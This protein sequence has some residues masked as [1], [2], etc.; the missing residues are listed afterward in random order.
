MQRNRSA[1]LGAS[2]PRLQIDYFI[3][4]RI[5]LVELMFVTLYSYKMHKFI[6]RSEIV[7]EEVVKVVT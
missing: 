2:Q 7:R 6:N 1:S 4:Y 5:S 3:Y